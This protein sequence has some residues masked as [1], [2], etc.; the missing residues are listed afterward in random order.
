MQKIKVV[1]IMEVG[2]GAEHEGDTLLQAIEEHVHWGMES[3]EDDLGVRSKIS[4]VQFMEEGEDE[5]S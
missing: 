4:S 1:I 3:I 5:S 2:Q